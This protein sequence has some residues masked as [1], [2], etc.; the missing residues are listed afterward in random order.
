MRKFK[1]PFNL[2]PLSPLERNIY[3]GV[4]AIAV[5]FL[6]TNWIFNVWYGDTLANYSLGIIHNGVT[7]FLRGPEAN[8][9]GSV[10]VSASSLLFQ[11]TLP[12]IL[13]FVVA[14]TAALLVLKSLGLIALRA[15]LVYVAPIVLTTLI[16]IIIYAILVVPPVTSLIDAIF[17]AYRKSTFQFDFLWGSWISEVVNTVSQLVVPAAVAVLAWVPAIAPEKE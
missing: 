9:L 3:A 4:S 1:L 5:W 10:V 12:T 15:K 13:G 16:G 8:S 17:P 7:D 14:A 11:Q 2:L 6:L